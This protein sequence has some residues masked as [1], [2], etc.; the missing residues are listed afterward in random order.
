MSDWLFYISTDYFVNT[1]NTWKRG[2]TA[3]KITGVNNRNT[4]T[5]CEILSKLTIKTA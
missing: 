3:L 1:G 5:R 4:R 2:N